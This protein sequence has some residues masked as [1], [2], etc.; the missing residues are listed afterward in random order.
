LRPV[1]AMSLHPNHDRRRS[2]EHALGRT[3]QNP[4]VLRLVPFDGELVGGPDDQ[5]TVVQR[6]RHRW[7]EPRPYRGV[8]EFAPRLV[9]ES[10]PSFFSRLLH[11]RMTMRWDVLQGRPESTRRLWKSQP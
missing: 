7:L 5:A 1:L 4:G 11:P 2:T 8:G 9:E 10:L 3:R 6:D